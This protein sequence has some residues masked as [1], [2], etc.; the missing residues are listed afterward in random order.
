[1]LGQFRLE[2][3]RLGQ[4]WLDQVIQRRHLAYLTPLSSFLFQIS[5]LTST[6][7]FLSPTDS[8]P[9]LSTSCQV[10]PALGVVK[11]SKTRSAGVRKG[12]ARS[13][14]AR[15]DQ[16]RIGLVFFEIFGQVRLGSVRYVRLGQIRLGYVRLG[17]AKSGQETL[18]QT[19]I[20]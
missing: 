7:K 18:G 3:V 17:Q 5:C 12:Q 1:M 11:V 6:D 4:C 15:L 8:D 19:R 2:L 14:Q 9:K 20:G 16:F 13:G 10:V